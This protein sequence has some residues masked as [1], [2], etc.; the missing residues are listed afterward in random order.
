MIQH[1]AWST[2]RFAESEIVQ[3]VQ[4]SRA[5]SLTQGV[6]LVQDLTLQLMKKREKEGHGAV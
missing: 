2:L 6:V 3:Q 5:M 4:L 1:G